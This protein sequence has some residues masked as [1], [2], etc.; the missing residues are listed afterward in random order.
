MDSSFIRSDELPYVSKAKRTTD[1]QPSVTFFA[2]SR[3][4]CGSRKLQRLRIDLGGV[5]RQEAH[6]G[7]GSGV[8]DLQPRG[9]TVLARNP[10]SGLR[11]TLK[12][13]YE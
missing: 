4:G 12:H 10:H 3:R 5:A 9:G 13:A 6:G 11:T 1:R 8:S 7:T 2:L